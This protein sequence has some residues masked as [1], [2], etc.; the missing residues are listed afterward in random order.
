MKVGIISDTHDHVAHI[1]T[2]TRKFTDLGIDTIL[3]AGD[4]CSPFT[5]PM[6]EGFMLIGVFGNN[7]GDHFRLIQQFRNISAEIHNEFH[8]LTMN[9]RKIALYHGTR[10]P[11]TDAL[12]KCGKYDLV[13]YGHIHTPVNDYHGDTLS[14]NPGSAHGFGKTPTI[15]IYDTETNTAEH[16]ELTLLQ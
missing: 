16:I 5:I 6:F 2:A 9:G 15:G 10:E 7:D 13:I 8:E 3:H 1:E 11:I 4:Y 14:F 12:L